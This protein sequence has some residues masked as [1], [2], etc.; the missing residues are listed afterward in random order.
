[1]EGDDKK[2]DYYRQR[3]EEVL[4]LVPTDA[5]SILDIGCGAARTWVGRPETRRVCGVELDPE[6]AKEAASHLDQVLLGNIEELELS[7]ENG[8]FDCIMLA[9][10]LEH[11][12][13]PWRVLRSLRPYLAPGGAIVSSIP[14]VQYYRVVRSLVAGKWEYRH[15]GILDRT[16]LRFFTL[17]SVKKLFSETGYTLQ[18]TRR[19][20]RASGKWRLL[21][22]LLFG[23]LENF[24]TYQYLVRAVPEK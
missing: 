4:A 13:D 2:P 11:L 15:Q 10:I 24:L 18:E 16:H 23:S 21:N 7:F 5:V 3:R 22:R 12:I 8:S 6:A 1:M 19:T 9:D 17:R 14:N 20:I